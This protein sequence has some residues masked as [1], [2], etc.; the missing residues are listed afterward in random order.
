MT[1]ECDLAS[2]S[3]SSEVL[4]ECWTLLSICGM[5]LYQAAS[6]QETDAKLE[7]SRGQG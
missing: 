4:A 2:P 5:G 6:W 1:G 3:E 7:Q